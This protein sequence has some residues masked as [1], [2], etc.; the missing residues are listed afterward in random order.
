MEQEKLTVSRERMHPQVLRELANIIV[1]PLS[2]TFER[3]WL[4][5]KVPED[6]KITS[7]TSFRTARRKI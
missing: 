7:V 1:R 4:S 2:I 6:W 5:R 3:S